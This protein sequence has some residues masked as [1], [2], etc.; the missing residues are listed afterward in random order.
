M[1]H[2]RQGLYQNQIKWIA[3]IAMTL[4]HI[5][6][7]LIYPGLVTAEISFSLR[8]ELAWGNR[9]AR[10]WIWYEVLKDIGLMTAP[11]MMVF[12]CE[13]YRYTRRLVRYFLRLLVA[14]VVA[15]PGFF[16]MNGWGYDMMFTLAILLAVVWV[17]R[18]DIRYGKVSD[19]QYIEM[20]EYALKDGD[21]IVYGDGNLCRNF[22]RVLYKCEN[23]LRFTFSGKVIAI[24]LL[25]AASLY[26]D[27]NVI[28]VP[29]IVLIC[30]AMTS[31]GW[32]KK[33]LGKM[34][35]CCIAVFFLT[36]L[37]GP[38]EISALHVLDILGETLGVSVGFALI[39]FLYNGQREPVSDSDGIAEKEIS[40]LG[41]QAMGMSDVK[42]SRRF[43]SWFNKY[44]FYI[45]YPLHIY[46]LV[47]LRQ[48]LYPIY[49]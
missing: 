32:D 20:Q 31:D 4:N 11:I 29:F 16:L 9:Y 43:E 7:T 13:G 18:A 22:N 8:P 24:S 6:H 19:E 39:Y 25:Y 5:A 38:E 21:K 17:L 14:G 40:A 26:C 47:I 23:W 28:S 45:Y 10:M 44:W 35:L 27:W 48:L 41:M 33:K 15:E 1:N 12:L 3:I 42:R 34:F 2:Q 46:V 49:I 30:Q 36:S 37:G